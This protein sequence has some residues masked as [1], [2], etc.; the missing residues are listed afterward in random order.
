[1][2]KIAFEYWL[3]LTFGVCC[4]MAM[5]GYC[6]LAFVGSCG[7]LCLMITSR[8]ELSVLYRRL[9]VAILLTWWFG[10]LL[11]LLCCLFDNWWC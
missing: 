1:M 10:V 11:C 2:H 7:L 6:T 3:L 9:M 8:F 4:V 5:G